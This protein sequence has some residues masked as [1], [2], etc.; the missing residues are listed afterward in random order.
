MNKRNIIVVIAIVAVILIGIICCFIFKNSSKEVVLEIHCGDIN[1]SNTYKEKDSF[2][3]KLPGEEFEI[4]IKKI[5][6][7]SV[8]LSS[9]KYGLYPQREDGTISLIDKVDSFKL[10]KNNELILAYQATDT[11]ENISITWN[12]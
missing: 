8:E 1:T 5:N 9:S 7:D 12:K 10:E 2:K 11:S 3:C 6:K 4:T